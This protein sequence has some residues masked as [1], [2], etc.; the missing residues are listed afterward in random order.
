MSAKIRIIGIEDGLF[1]A[2]QQ[3]TLD[4]P[5]VVHRSVTLEMVRRQ[6]VQ[7]PTRGPISVAASI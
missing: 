6:V 4:R 3:P 7:R 5:V 2:L 1:G